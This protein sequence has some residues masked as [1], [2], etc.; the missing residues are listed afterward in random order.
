MSCD[1]T[2]FTVTKGLNNTFIFTIKADGTT[3]PMEI[4]EVS[5]TFQ[6]QLILLSDGSVALTKSLTVTN[7][8]AGQV[9]LTLLAAETANLVV[10]K[11]SKTD[12]YYVRPTYKLILDCST[13]NNGD[14][15]ARVLEVYVD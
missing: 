13:A 4:V 2:K 5:D 15:I 6:A 8:A 11:G 1:I 14:F 7:A 9:S 10:D 3:L 12:R